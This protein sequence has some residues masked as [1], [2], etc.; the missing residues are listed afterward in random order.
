MAEVYNWQL[1]RPIGYIYPEAHPQRQFV[2]VFNINRCIGCQTCT[3]ACKAT[4]T[5]SKG[6]EYMWWN[7]VESKPY[8]SYPKYWD[9]KILQKLEEAHETAGKEMTWD[10]SAVG[11]QSP[12]GV[13]QGL[14]ITEAAA[15][16]QSGDQ[17]LG[18]LP[19]DTEWSA[20][21]FYEDTSTK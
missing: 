5:F 9:V 12:Y 8:G 18:Y 11:E 3:G 13:Y 19:Q 2:A 17:A 6:Q 4:W 14:T 21:N 1:G 15:E 16:T 7:N 10:T 20:P